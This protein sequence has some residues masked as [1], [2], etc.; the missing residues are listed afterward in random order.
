MIP[1]KNKTIKEN[2][3][4]ERMS[5]SSEKDGIT[6]SVTVKK[7]ENG[8]VICISKHGYKGDKYMDET[9]EYI[10]T[11]NP[12]E[13]KEEEIETPLEAQKKVYDLLDGFF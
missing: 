4:E 5:Y 10:S 1:L 8:Y 12:L 6:K 3:M 7:V 9:K 13:K 11:K 2:T